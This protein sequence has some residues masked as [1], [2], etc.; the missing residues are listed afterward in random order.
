MS[1]RPK[2]SA[3]YA[4]MADHSRAAAA[5]GGAGAS[6][7]DLL[8]MSCE[9]AQPQPPCPLQA[10][11]QSQLWSLSLPRSAGKPLSS[12]FSFF[13]YFQLWLLTSANFQLQQI[14]SFWSF[15]SSWSQTIKSLFNSLILDLKWTQIRQLCGE[16][17]NGP[18]LDR[19]FLPPYSDNSLR[20]LVPFRSTVCLKPSFFSVLLLSTCPR[21]DV[22]ETRGGGR[23]TRGHVF[24]LRS[25]EPRSSVEWWI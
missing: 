22:T 3:A 9:E 16:G 6:N 21:R 25:L 19:Q 20:I 11:D 7:A 23:W 15:F 5:A 17:P 2:A 8:L 24:P 14:L 4:A 18:R 12:V 10:G 13:Y 1:A